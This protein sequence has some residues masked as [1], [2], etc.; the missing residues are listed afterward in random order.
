MKDIDKNKFP[1]TES[2]TIEFKTSFTS[3]C[4]ETLVAFANIKGGSIYIGIADNAE[5]KGVTTGT[6]SVSQWIN[7]IK[8]KTDPALI[9]DVDEID[10]EVPVERNVYEFLTKMELLREGKLTNVGFLLLMKNDSAL[11]GIELGHFQNEITIKDGIT[12]S[13]DLVSEVDIR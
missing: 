13:T 9:P 10:R 8:S 5:I 11:S 6:E 4:I 3:E 12:I 2:D 7:E 1:P